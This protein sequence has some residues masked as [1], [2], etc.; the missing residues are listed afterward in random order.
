VSGR[1]L[2]AKRGI[3]FGERDAQNDAASQEALKK[4]IGTLDV[5]VLAVGDSKVKGFE[6][7]QWQAAL[8]GA[9]YPR[10]RLPGQGASAKR[11]PYQGMPPAPPATPPGGDAKPR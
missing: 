5:P 11:D 1:D 6:E 9:G 8:D 4:L 7:S 2:L 10:T 3:P